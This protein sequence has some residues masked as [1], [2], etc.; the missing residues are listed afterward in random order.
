MDLL[1]LMVQCAPTVH[2]DTMQRVIRVESSFNPYAIGVVGARLQRQPRSHA[3][4]LATVRWLDANGYNYS[5]GLAQVN[6]RNFR[7]H[8]LTPE[9]A[10]MPCPNLGAGGAILT[11]CFTRARKSHPAQAALRAAFSCYESGNFVTGFRDGYVRKIVAPST[12]SPPPRHP[13]PPR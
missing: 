1:G 11:T 4:A 3:E 6:K 9:T 5:V 12:T 13:A 7:A 10:L 2:P 8:G